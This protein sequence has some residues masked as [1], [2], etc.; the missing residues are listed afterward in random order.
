MKFLDEVQIEV[1]AGN[2]GN[3]CVSFRRERFIPNGGPDGGNGGN[4]GSIYLQADENL[5]TLIEYRYQSQYHAKSGSNGAKRNQTGASGRDLYLRVPMGTEVFSADT[6]ESIGDL[7]EKDQR[8]LVARGGQ[9]GAGN[10]C[11]KSSVNRSPREHILGQAGQAHKLQLSLKL[12]SEVG[13]VGLP[14]SGKST[15]I[16]VVSNA[17]PKIA[18]YPFTTLTPQ[19]G[20]VR[21]EGWRHFVIADIPGLIEG[22]SSGAGLGLQFLK[23]LERTR[24]LLHLVD[25]APLDGS[26]PIENIHLI[27]Q[28]LS[29][30]SQRLVEKPCWIV[31]SKLDTIPLSEQKDTCDRLIGAIKSR[32]GSGVSVFSISSLKCIGTADLCLNIMSFLEQRTATHNQ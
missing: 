8:L 23:H 7:M 6:Q 1:T 19:L 3:G 17:K 2:G 16:H 9:G 24:L 21:V 20:V 18:D 5:N 15:F 29:Q 14:N 13:L 11:F 10:H 26:D 28:E 31:L 12:L 32:L 30:Y 27:H 4:G 22:A 25:V